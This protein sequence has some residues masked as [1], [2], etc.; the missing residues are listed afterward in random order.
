MIDFSVFVY[1]PELRRSVLLLEPVWGKDAKQAFTKARKNL[2]DVH[3][4]RIRV[5][6]INHDR[7]QA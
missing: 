2:P 1:M 6:R 4:S 5:E 7:T 3:S